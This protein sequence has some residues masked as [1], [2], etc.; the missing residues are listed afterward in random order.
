MLYSDVGESVQRSGEMKE[1]VFFE[2]DRAVTS[3]VN[4]AENFGKRH[5]HLIRDVQNMKKD[6]PNFGE[7]F[8]YHNDRD[9]YGRFRKTYLMNRDGFTLL[10]MGFTGSKAMEF[11]LKYIEA[12]NEMEKRLQNNQ[13]KL[14]SSKEQL[15]A[16]MKLSLETAEDVN[17]LRTDVNMLKDTMRIDTREEAQIRNLANRIVVKALGGKKSNAYKVMSRKAFPRFWNEFKRFFELARYGDLPKKQ[18]DEAI[19]WMHEWQPDTTTR[20]E[21]KSANE[22]MVMEDD[23]S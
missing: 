14:L 5:D 19:E 4:I 13:P 11:K 20:I 9:S 12:F 18:F 2:N 8:F 22:Q 6:V 10:V 23:V 17:E 7:M 3:T 1:L 15:M 16:S 21:I